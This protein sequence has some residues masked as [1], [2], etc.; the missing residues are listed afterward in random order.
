MMSAL[1]N[2]TQEQI[3]DARIVG[4]LRMKGEGEKASLPDDY[5][6]VFETR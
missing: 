5:R 6:I 1:R 4:E 3:V 2:H